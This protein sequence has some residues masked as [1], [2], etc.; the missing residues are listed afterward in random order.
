MRP[1]NSTH[2][3]FLEGYSP[4]SHYGGIL[5]KQEM[6]LVL[7]VFFWPAPTFSNEFE[8]PGDEPGAKFPPLLPSVNKLRLQAEKF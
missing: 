1:C 2:N 8:E 4:G 3:R 7:L 6:G 5:P